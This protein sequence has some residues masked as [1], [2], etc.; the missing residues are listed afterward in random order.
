MNIR[1]ARKIM[2]GRMSERMRRRLSK[3]YPPYESELGTTYP[4]WH[5]YHRIRK[6]Y[7]VVFRKVR[8]Y[9]DKFKKL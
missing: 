3:L 9:G 2:S 1:Q 8:K 6:A 7:I 5:R 4:S